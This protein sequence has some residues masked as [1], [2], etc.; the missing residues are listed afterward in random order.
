MD[1][2]LVRAEL[3]TP[4]LGETEGSECARDTRWWLLMDVGSQLAPESR[5]KRFESSGWSF[6]VM[7][8]GAW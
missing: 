2:Q 6:A 4:V 5:L 3:N 1:G 7:W 8:A